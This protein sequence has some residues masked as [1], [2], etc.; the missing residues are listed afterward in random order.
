MGLQLHPCHPNSVA[1]LFFGSRHFVKEGLEEKKIFIPV[2]LSFNY[3]MPEPMHF[4]SFSPF[5][6]HQMSFLSYGM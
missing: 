3:G 4:V 5:T 1:V 6:V 2:G